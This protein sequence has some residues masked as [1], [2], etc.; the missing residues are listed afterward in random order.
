MPFVLHSPLRTTDEQCRLRSRKLA[1][2][3]TSFLWKEEAI[4][5]GPP[6]IQ[7]VEIEVRGQDQ[8]SQSSPLGLVILMRCFH[9]SHGTQRQPKATGLQTLISFP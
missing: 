4:Q 7:P 6:V 8:V 5:G 3:P 9:G 1:A 2:L